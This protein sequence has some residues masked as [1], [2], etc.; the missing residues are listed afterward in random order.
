MISHLVR[1]A[2]P[3]RMKQPCRGTHGCGSQTTPYRLSNLFLICGPAGN[4]RRMPA[5]SVEIHMPDLRCQ[6][7]P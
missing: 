5:H 3:N 1:E 4:C 6:L 2:N 7:N